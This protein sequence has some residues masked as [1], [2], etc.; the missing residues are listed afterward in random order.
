MI[1]DKFLDKLGA[2]TSNMHLTGLNKF[3][4]TKHEHN[5]VDI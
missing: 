2:N 1:K 4:Q 5:L 3:I